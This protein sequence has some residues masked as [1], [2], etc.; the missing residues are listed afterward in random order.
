MTL[1]RTRH[2]AHDPAVACCHILLIKL[3]MYILH[4]AHLAMTPTKTRF[5]PSPMRVLKRGESSDT[6]GLC[7]PHDDW[8]RA[9]VSGHRA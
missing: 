7:R 9:A 6:K 3:L 4:P 8:Q 5:A 1:H 2:D